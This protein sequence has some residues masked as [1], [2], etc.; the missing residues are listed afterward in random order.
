VLGFE[1]VEIIAEGR[2]GKRVC[3]DFSIIPVQEVVGEGSEGFAFC[4]EGFQGGAGGGGEAMG[5]LARPLDAE[6]G[7]VGGFRGFDV[8]AR[9]FAELFGGLSNVENVVDDL[10]GE[11]EGLS[12][13]GERIEAGRSG[14]RAHGAEAD[15]GGEQR[16]GLAAMDVFEFGAVDLLPLAFQIGD[17]STDQPLAAGSRGQF[18]D[19][20]MGL[21]TRGRLGFGEDLEGHGEQGVAGEN[22]DAF[23]IDLV[24]GGP[25][26]AQV[27]VVHAR[28]IVVD[29]G[30]RVDAL[31]G[32]GGRQG[33][34]DRA[35]AGLGGGESQ[36]GPEPLST[37]KDAVAHGL[38]DGG[39]FDRGARKMAVKRPVNERAAG[40]K[41][42]FQVHAGGPR[43]K[44]E[45]KKGKWKMEG[46]RR[47]E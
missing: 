24:R 10:E 34:F 2:N 4:A 46:E 1:G 19:E 25:A 18:G 16:G 36:N 32:A 35:A 39:G 31:D 29:E 15:A 47:G 41:I 40:G 27:V 14:V 6:D 21:V 33:A 45:S 12:E 23:A 44:S 17:L 42:V 38:V 8:F 43:V 9:G 13:C 22:G 7:R 20:G 28:E 30:I 3:A 37:S 11:A 26:P 5:F